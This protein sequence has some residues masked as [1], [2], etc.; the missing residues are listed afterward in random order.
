MIAGILHVGISRRSVEGLGRISVS[1]KTG[2]EPL[3]AGEMRAGPVLADF[4]A[5][6]RSDLLDNLERG[7]LAEFI[8]ATALGIPTGGTRVN[9]DPWDLTTPDG[10]RV[11]VK[12]AAYLQSWDQQRL[13][14]ISFSTRETRAWDG[15]S[16]QFTG[17]A[18]RAPR[19]MCSRCWPIPTRRR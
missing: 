2:G 15:D 12:S 10:I 5:W 17:A 4:W 19:Y 3:T 13:S 7:V 16:G 6:S 1:R 14:A 8:V 18:G 9:W 11:E